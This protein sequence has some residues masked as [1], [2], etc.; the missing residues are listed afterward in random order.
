M[1]TQN[2]LAFSLKLLLA[3]FALQ[4]FGCK[5]ATDLDAIIEQGT[6]NLDVYQI[7][8]EKVDGF[9]PSGQ[10]V[11]N[12]LENLG[13]WYIADTSFTYSI[14]TSGSL[15]YEGLYMK[16]IV[17]EANYN[18]YYYLN[19][20]AYLQGDK[21]RQ[22][23]ITVDRDPSGAAIQDWFNVKRELLNTPGFPPTYA[24]YTSVTDGPYDNYRVLFRKLSKNKYLIVFN[25]R[26]NVEYRLEISR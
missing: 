26:E 22:K 4:W 24:F 3:F 16:A 18:T 5:K 17:N 12:R 25:S 19:D 10:P 21:L 2:H 14:N 8:Y 13:K 23:E 9:I 1:L 20:I 11:V 6:W 15:T 7:T